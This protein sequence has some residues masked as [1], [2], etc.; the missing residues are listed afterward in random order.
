MGAPVAGKLKHAPPMQLVCLLRWGRLQPANTRLCAA[1]VRPSCARMPKAEP[2]AT[3]FQH[4][5]ERF[6]GV[7]LLVPGHLLGSAGDHD[8][9]AVLAAVGPQVNDPIRGLHR[10][11]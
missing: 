2:Y 4:L 6:G 1:P 10:S 3:S 11:E 8:A 5:A 9:A 7:A